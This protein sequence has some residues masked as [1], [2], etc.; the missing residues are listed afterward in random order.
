MKSIIAV[1]KLEQ[2]DFFAIVGLTSVM[3]QSVYE[4]L[5]IDFF[6]IK[7]Q[8]VLVR[9]NMSDACPK[10]KWQKI[11][12]NAVALVSPRNYNSKE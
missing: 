11:E 10:T 5:E 8:I 6:Q 2:R 9:I 12:N 1:K 3:C 4:G 7:N